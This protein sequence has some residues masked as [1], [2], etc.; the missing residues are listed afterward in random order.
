ME[1]RSPLQAKSLDGPCSRIAF[2]NPDTSTTRQIQ[3]QR[4]RRGESA[5]VRDAVI[6]NHITQDAAERAWHALFDA[7]YR[8]ELGL[9]LRRSKL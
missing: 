1:N 3:A 2:E 7:H 8:S 6:G 5:N 9:C 4:T